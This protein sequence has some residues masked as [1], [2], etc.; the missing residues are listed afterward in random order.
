MNS[1]F[2]DALFGSNMSFAT[3]SDVLSGFLF[4]GLLDDF[5]TFLG[6]GN[7]IGCIDSGPVSEFLPSILFGCVEAG[8]CIGVVFNIRY[9]IYAI[10]TTQNSIR[11]GRDIQRI[12]SL[13]SKSIFGLNNEN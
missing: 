1:V 10:F 9:N 11:F 12:L 6:D 8:I 5:C 3:W 7:M 13:K 2:G 4:M